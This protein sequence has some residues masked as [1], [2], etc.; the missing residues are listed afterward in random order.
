MI[1]AFLLLLDSINYKCV[2]IH[3]TNMILTIV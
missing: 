2:Y 3:L 1:Y